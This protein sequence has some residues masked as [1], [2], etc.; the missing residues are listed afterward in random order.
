M[1]DNPQPLALVAESGPS[2]PS[3][4][5]PLSAVGGPNALLVAGACVFALSLIYLLDVL[6]PPGTSLGAAAVLRRNLFIYGAG[7]IIIP[8]TGI[9]IIDLLITALG[10]A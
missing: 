1:S 3:W 2:Q 4:A 5:R 6:T 8:F 7:G 10:L 9:K